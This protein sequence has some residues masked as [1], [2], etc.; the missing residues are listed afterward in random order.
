MLP[1]H[2][3][4]VELGSHADDPVP[5]ANMGQ[6]IDPD[7]VQRY[8]EEQAAKGALPLL[9]GDAFIKLVLGVSESR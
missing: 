4:P 6:G 8:D 7:D 3:T 2:P 5:V 9:E 1:D